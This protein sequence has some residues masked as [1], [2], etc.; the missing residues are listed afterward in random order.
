MQE[1][2]N[3]LAVADITEKNAVSLTHNEIL[4]YFSSLL[5]SPA[6]PFGMPDCIKDNPEAKRIEQAMLEFREALKMAREGDFSYKITAKGFIGGTLKG[7]QANLNHMTWLTRCVADGDLEQRM[8]FIG[9]FSSAFNSMTERLSFALKELTQ[10]QEKLQNLTQELLQEVE[11]RKVA[12]ERLQKEEERWLLV[13]QCSRD[14]IWDISLKPDVPPFYSPRLLELIQVDP[15]VIRNFRNWVEFF[16]PD[17]HETLNQFQSVFCGKNASDLFVMEYRLLCGDGV[18]RWFQTK[19]MSV[20]DPITCEP[21]RVIGVTADIQ[22]RKEREE[23]YSHRATHDILTELPN[24]ALFNDRL[25]KDIAF[26]KRDASHLAVIML[27]LDEFKSVNDTLGHQAGDELLVEVSVRL[28]KSIRESD[29]AARLGGDEF[30][31]LLPFGVGKRKD[32]VK[33]LNR[34]IT[35]LRKKFCLDGRPHAITASMGVSIY[36]ED[37]DNAE[38][39]LKHADEAMYHIKARGRNGCA[40]WRPEKSYSIVKFGE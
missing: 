32:I 33:A 15:E 25:H 30:A 7:L 19:G 40:F 6:L 29:T 1:Q 17:D 13:M 36:P 12:E 26:A 34:I 22:K 27:D 11:I 2:R 9:E 23:H 28:L 24:R 35:N 18:Y 16:H 14:G 3:E 4:G 20:R 10:R 5:F 31:L 8:D 21:V 38:T 39:L 37:G